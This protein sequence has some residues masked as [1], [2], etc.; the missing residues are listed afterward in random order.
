M[1]HICIQSTMRG[2][3]TRMPSQAHHCRFTMGLPAA[4]A[5]AAAGDKP[6]ACPTTR[7]VHVVSHAERQEKPSAA[8]CCCAAASVSGRHSTTWS[9]DTL[10]NQ[11]RQRAR[12][13]GKVCSTHAIWV[14]YHLPGTAY[15][16]C[17]WRLHGPF[18]SKMLA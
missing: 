10:Q 18:A 12:E 6:G 16:R 9:Q 1:A 11:P 5:H 17:R 7:C 13:Y 15:A 14:M 8:A 3:V 2:L 4:L